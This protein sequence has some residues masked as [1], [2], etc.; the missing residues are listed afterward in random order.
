[1]RGLPSHHM[2]INPEYLT[3]SHV[4]I[5]QPPPPYTRTVVKKCSLHY[6]LGEVL[7]E[8]LLY[9]ILHYSISTSTVLMATHSFILITPTGSL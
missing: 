4:H 9:Y 3:I 6:S 2:H 1:M 7:G 5:S 8:G